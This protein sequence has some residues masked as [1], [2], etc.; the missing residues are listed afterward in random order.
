MCYDVWIVYIHHKNEHYLFTPQD[1]A[2]KQKAVARYLWWM[3]IWRIIG[4]FALQQMLGIIL[5]TKDFRVELQ[6]DV[7]THHAW[8]QDTAK[9]ILLQLLRHRVPNPSN[10]LQS[11]TPKKIKL[12]WS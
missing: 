12:G 10:N 3:A 8:N 7:L 2:A 4:M 6:V 11:Q 9:F 1:T 5:S